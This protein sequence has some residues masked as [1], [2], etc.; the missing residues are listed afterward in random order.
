VLAGT[1]LVNGPG[2][3]AIIKSCTSL[4]HLDVTDAARFPDSLFALLAE[5]CHNLKSLRLRG[6]RK[7][8]NA[9]LSAIV[10]SST[11]LTSLDI[12]GC[13]RISERVG[14]SP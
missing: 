4:T 8:T 1:P 14:V 7:L 11:A 10:S 5:H 6:C 3:E 9:T 13:V 2:L 12:G